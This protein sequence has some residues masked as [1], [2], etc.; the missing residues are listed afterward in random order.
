M[1]K[2]IAVLLVAAMTMALAVPAFAHQVVVVDPSKEA[3]VEEKAAEETTEA[4]VEEKATEAVVEETATEAAEATEATEATEE[5]TEAVV[6][7]TKVEPIVTSPNKEK[8]REVVLEDGTAVT[9]SKVK[10][11]K[12]LYNTAAQ[13]SILSQT[14]QAQMKIMQEQLMHLELQLVM[15]RGTQFVPDGNF[16]NGRRYTW[17]LADSRVEKVKMV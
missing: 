14:L 10:E 16:I 1:K 12:T 15:V 5:T 6:E 9:Y 8:D 13:L 3:A 2:K 11:P 17:L 7:E 4:V